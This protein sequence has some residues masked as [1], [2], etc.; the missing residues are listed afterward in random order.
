MTAVPALPVKLL[1]KPFLCAFEFPLVGR[2]ENTWSCPRCSSQPV[3]M[4]HFFQV[5]VSANNIL[6]VVFN[7]GAAAEVEMLLQMKSWCPVFSG[8][9]HMPDRSAT[10]DSFFDSTISHVQWTFPSYHLAGFP[11]DPY[12]GLV[13]FGAR[14][15][16]C[17][18][19]AACCH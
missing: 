18:Q 10:K 15:A 16:A 7:M 12:H 3:P 13:L 9:P 11:T 14:W 6:D 2:M 1:S 8:M 17:F 5:S 4:E 19:G